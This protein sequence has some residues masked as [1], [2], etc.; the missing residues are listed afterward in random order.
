[1]STSILAFRLSSPIARSEP[2]VTSVEGE[3]PEWHGTERAHAGC[4][5]T[6]RGTEG[7]CRPRY[8]GSSMTCTEWGWGSKECWCV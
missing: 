2:V 3:Q 6:N 7:Y 5:C 1:M 8:E 4:Y